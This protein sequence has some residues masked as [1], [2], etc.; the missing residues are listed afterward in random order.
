MS[1]RSHSTGLVGTAYGKCNNLCAKIRCYG[2][3]VRVMLFFDSGNLYVIDA[4][5]VADAFEFSM[6]DL[7]DKLKLWCLNHDF[8]LNMDP[9][10]KPAQKLLANEYLLSLEELKLKSII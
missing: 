4:V 2:Y 6:K 8:S 7:V 10:W 3:V 9:E 1:Y 5:K